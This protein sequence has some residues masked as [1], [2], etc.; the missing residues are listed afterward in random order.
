MF[1]RGKTDN[2]TV[3]KIVVDV[4]Y[5]SDVKVQMS[6]SGPELFIG[7]FVLESNF[8]YFQSGLAMKL[9]L[10]QIVEADES[11][12]DSNL[13]TA[14]S[15]AGLSTR[16]G[17]FKMDCIYEVIFDKFHKTIQTNEKKRNIGI[18]LSK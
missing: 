18:L 13:E 9:Q 1:E 14:C 15:T 3:A 6:E 5:N 10:G 16:V 12:S 7:N 2:N 4:W 11:F 8:G 17:S